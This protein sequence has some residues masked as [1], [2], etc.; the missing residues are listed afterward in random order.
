MSVHTP[1]GQVAR[2]AA[3]KQRRVAGG[4]HGDRVGL[5]GLVRLV[6]VV[7]DGAEFFRRGEPAR[8]GVDVV[9]AAAER[10]GERRRIQPDRQPADHQ[11]TAIGRV[12]AG[13]FRPERAD[14]APA[15]GDVVRQ[16]RDGDRVDGV[17]GSETSIASA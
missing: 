12:K 14:R 13:Q 10:R 7:N 8:V 16:R 1:S 4:V 5:P 11:H 6:G 2:S 15:V 3:D 9:D 17:G